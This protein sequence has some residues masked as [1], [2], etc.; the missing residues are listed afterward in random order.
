MATRILAAACDGHVVHR[1]RVLPPS[2]TPISS[3]SHASST[4]LRMEGHRLVLLLRSALSTLA[5]VVA[6]VPAIV[7]VFVVT[8]SLKCGKGM[9]EC[10]ILSLL[11]LLLHGVV[12]RRL[13]LLH[14]RYST[15]EVKRRSC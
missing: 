13:L 5:V 3:S 10:S 1:G 15:R 2:A 7:A 11:S 8:A 14:Q 9:V 12:I 6:I 4:Q